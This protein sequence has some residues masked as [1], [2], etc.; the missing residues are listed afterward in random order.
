M[1]DGSN[2]QTKVIVK[3]NIDLDS[4]I[5]LIESDHRGHGGAKSWYR[6]SK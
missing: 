6:I 2:D 3:Q 1:D 4:H 5:K